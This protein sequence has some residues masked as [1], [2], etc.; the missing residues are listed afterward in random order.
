MKETF[1]PIKAQSIGLITNYK[2]TFSCKH[3][4]Y[5][6]SPYIDENINENNL[7]K[8][9]DL[10]NENLPYVDLHIGGG[11]PLLN[12]ETI[13]KLLKYIH[14][15]SN[16]NLEYLE[17]NGFLLLKN[18]DKKLQELKQTG[19]KTLLLS[20][21]PF[22]GEFISVNQL[23][24]LLN[25]I[26]EYFGVNGLFPWH[27]EYLQYMEKLAPNS[28]HKIEEYFQHFDITDITTQLTG[29]TYIHPGGRAAFFLAKYL[30]KYKA[31]DLLNIDCS[32]KLASPIHAHIDYAGNYI[33]GFCSG[34]RIGENTFFNPKKLYNEGINL[35]NYPILDILI[36]HGLKG[37]LNFAIDKGYKSQPE[38]YVSPC[39]LCLDIRLFLFNKNHYNSLYPR[40]FYIDLINRL[41]GGT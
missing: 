6:S 31:E 30:K 10:I 39:H 34:L 15:K 2:C 1:K 8:I 13:I 4:L 38:G 18:T 28:T 41:K 25:K 26:I 20:I 14:T 22:H 3:C 33:T 29:I 24:F 21:D 17:T 12:Y 27:P 23:K 19:L 7:Y 5:A 35:K 36:N 40:F 37:L 9:I 16:I 11:E 32:S